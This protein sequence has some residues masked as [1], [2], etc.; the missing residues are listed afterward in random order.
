MSRHTVRLALLILAVSLVSS[1][2]GSA[3]R[4]G[5]RGP[6]GP[7]S[8]VLDCGGER[9]TLTDPDRERFWLTREDCLEHYLVRLE[10]GL[11]SDPRIASYDIRTGEIPAS[12]IPPSSE[13]RVGASSEYPGDPA[14]V[15]PV[16]FDEPLRWEPYITT[17]FPESEQTTVPGE[18]YTFAIAKVDP[19]RKGFEIHL[20]A[21][22]GT[23]VHAIGVVWVAYD[24]TA[25]GG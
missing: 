15:I 10:R 18:R 25:A 16:R 3:P 9:E 12:E 11:A 23:V 6:S 8:P 19:T 22:N 13:W 2:C 7:P 5:S 21:L 1:A 4:G 24:T 20:V 17:W 14:Y